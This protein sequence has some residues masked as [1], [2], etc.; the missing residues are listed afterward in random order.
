MSLLDPI[1]CWK[2]NEKYAKGSFLLYQFC[3]L[4]VHS[5]LFVDTKTPKA[6]TDSFVWIKYFFILYYFTNKFIFKTSTAIQ[7]KTNSTLDIYMT[8]L[9]DKTIQLRLY[10]IAHIVI[11]SSYILYYKQ[12][13]FFINIYCM[14]A[15]Y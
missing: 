15:F 8:N 3:I 2:K 11:D 5:F 1:F 14:I 6:Q 12:K 4:P 13:V 9:V 10:V 7:K